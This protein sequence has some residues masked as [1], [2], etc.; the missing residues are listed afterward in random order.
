MFRSKMIDDFCPDSIKRMQNSIKIPVDNNKAHELLV[1]TIEQ[2]PNNYHALYELACDYW[3]ADQRTE[4]VSE[5]DGVKAEQY[6]NQARVYAVQAH[7]ATYLT[8]IDTYLSKVKEWKE[9]LQKINSKN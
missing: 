9:N 4:A 3:K 6:F 2:N 7:D 8:M 1:L 5:R